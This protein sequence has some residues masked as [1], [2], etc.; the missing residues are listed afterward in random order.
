MLVRF[1]DCF[2]LGPVCQDLSP[3]NIIRAVN[4]SFSLS[5]LTIENVQDKADP[6]TNLQS[7]S[8]I[9]CCI[10]TDEAPSLRRIQSSV[11]KQAVKYVFHRIPCLQTYI[12]VKKMLNFKER[13]CFSMSLY[14]LVDPCTCSA[15]ENQNHK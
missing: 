8:R 9:H 7:Y 1:T 5:P 12:K 14:I 2:S 13:E 10:T 3:A 6:L 15:I 4:F 11:K